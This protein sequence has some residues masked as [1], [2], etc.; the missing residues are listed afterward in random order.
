MA[1]GNALLN[2]AKL[3]SQNRVPDGFYD[4]RAYFYKIY[5]SSE[6]D[7]VSNRNFYQIMSN[8][9]QD[10]NI[11]FEFDN[12]LKGSWKS[13]GKINTLASFKSKQ[14]VVF[15][16]K[17]FKKD[18]D[19]KAFYLVTDTPLQNYQDEETG[20]VIQTNDLVF[21]ITTEPFI[22]GLDKTLT[23]E[24]TSFNTGEWT[25]TDTT[26][27]VEQIKLINLY[28]NPL[29]GNNT[30][31][32]SYKFAADFL[33]D[34]NQGLKILND[35]D[36]PIDYEI[37][38]DSE[39]PNTG[40]TDLY[41]VSYMQTNGS[42][43]PSLNIFLYALSGIRIADELISLGAGGV[44]QTPNA[45][46]VSGT[47]GFSR[48]QGADPNYIL[49]DGNAPSDINQ[50]EQEFLQNSNYQTF[51]TLEQAG[52]SDAN[53]FWYKEDSSNPENF[54]ASSISPQNELADVPLMPAYTIA[55][56]TWQGIQNNKNT[57]F[58]YWFAGDYH[59]N[60]AAVSANIDAHTKYFIP[61][62]TSLRE[63]DI[64]K[65][66][67]YLNGFL[68]GSISSYKGIVLESLP[69]TLEDNEVTNYKDLDTDSID[70]K[71]IIT[72]FDINDYYDSEKDSIED[73]YPTTYSNQFIYNLTTLYKNKKLFP[74]PSAF[75][76]IALNNEMLFNDL[77]AEEKRNIVIK[78]KNPDGSIYVG[79]WKSVLISM[80]GGGSNFTMEQ[81]DKNY[82]YAITSDGKKTNL[83]KKDLSWYKNND[84]RKTVTSFSIVEEASNES[85]F[86]IKK[87]KNL[88]KEEIQK[89]F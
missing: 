86:A 48:E 28:G 15:E 30:S 7:R 37:I 17:D 88:N 42:N 10:I 45:R 40:S 58:D 72:S 18:I 5:T 82:D 29:V 14:K 87:I 78:L 75:N 57:D 65:A 84:R 50:Q 6:G 81:F 8:N 22:I 25:Y 52:K 64:D 44:G 1:E 54:A 59:I 79:R 76:A 73:N 35:D 74:N 61:E 33:L 20:Q 71:Y 27:G 11:T 46:T 21:W 19:D 49:I 2:K 77:S 63:R 26:T 34:A 70:G 53:D 51:M 47:I 39:N 55:K 3:Q 69:D 16:S 56:L 67:N 41:D 62:P 31:Y 23:V 89:L 24:F 83:I 60:L 4:E 13:K 66:K 68:N 36:Q 32:L 38:F 9:A 80:I 43:S 12:F 85:S